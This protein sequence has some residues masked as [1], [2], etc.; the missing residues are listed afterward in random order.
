[1]I[2][3]IKPELEGDAS[4]RTQ[5]SRR[6]IIV[7]D[8]RAGGFENCIGWEVK[9]VQLARPA[10]GISSGNSSSNTGNFDQSHIVN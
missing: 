10:A 6:R 8:G 2:R 3:G 1:M 5:L 9:I 4:H 7:H